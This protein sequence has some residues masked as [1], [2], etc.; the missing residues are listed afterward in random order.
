[1]CHSAWTVLGTALRFAYRLG[2][3]VENQD[4]SFSVARRD[5]LHCT[6]WCLYWLENKLC[7]ITG[8]PSIFTIEK[9]TPRDGPEASVDN[10]TFGPDIRD[11]FYDV[12]ESPRKP[13][14]TTV[15]PQTSVAESS[16][17]FYAAVEL[18]VIMRTILSS[19]YSPVCIVKSAKEMR[20]SMVYLGQRLDRW[21][22]SLPDRFVFHRSANGTTQHAREAVLLGFQA[23]S[24]RILLTRPC[25]G[26]QGEAWERDFDASFARFSGASCVEAAKLMVDLLPDHFNHHF[27]C[28][29]G[30]WWCQV[31]YLM[32]AVSVF[33]LRLSYPRITP[34]EGMGLVQYTRKVSRWLQGLRSP[35]AVRA[36]TV[37]NELI[38]PIANKWSVTGIDLRDEDYLNE[39]HAR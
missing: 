38:E 17:H 7:A 23:C 5:M 30:P 32:Q 24:A 37:V 25:L 10:T 35:A 13:S 9:Q 14:S 26:A 3:H 4:Q 18:S 20:E 6:W 15:R 29:Q 36:R 11:R 1:M 34:Q 19:L 12:P 33:L 31:Y 22:M 28:D 27:V 2:L 8:R 39:G 16:A 21:E